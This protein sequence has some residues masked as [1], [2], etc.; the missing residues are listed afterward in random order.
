MRLAG[1]LTPESGA[2][3]YT[4]AHKGTVI[5]NFKRRL[6]RKWKQNLSISIA[7]HR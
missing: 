2:H 5:L 7:G 1:K 4:N 3:S 6:S